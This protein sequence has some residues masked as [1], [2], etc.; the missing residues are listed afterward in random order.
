MKLLTKILDRLQH[1]FTVA[2]IHLL[3]AQNLR[4]MKKITKWQNKRIQE[5][6]KSIVETRCKTLREELKTLGEKYKY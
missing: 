5:M 2:K 6:K 1:H 3:N 4:K